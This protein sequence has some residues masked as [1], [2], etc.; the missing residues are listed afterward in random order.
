SPPTAA[1]KTR[2]QPPAKLY[3]T[4]LATRRIPTKGFQ[5]DQSISSPFPKLLGANDVPFSGQVH[6]AGSDLNTLRRDRNRAD[7]DVEQTV[8]HP[9]A[10]FQV[11]TARR[12]IQILDA[13][14]AEPTRTQITDAMKIYERDVLRNVTWQP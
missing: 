12:I 9:N 1:R 5:V 7:Y 2:F 4:G 11:Q 13:A 8:A 14:K 6:L 10:L 3:W